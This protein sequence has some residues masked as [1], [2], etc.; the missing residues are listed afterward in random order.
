VWIQPLFL[1]LQLMAVSVT[2]ATVIGV[3]GAWAASSLEVSG[4]WG[5]LI[6]RCFLASLVVAIA[7]PMVLHA[8][9][10]EATAGKFGWM[11]MTQT[12]A[13][14][15]GTG[16]YGFFGGLFAC[17]WVHGLVGA[18]LVA[19]ATWYGVR[20][21]PSALIQQSRLEMGPIEAWWRVRL[22]LA[23]PWLLASLLAT[24]ALAATEM[25]V[26]DLYGYRTLADEFYLFY[27]ADPSIVSVLMTCFLP[28]A[29]TGVALTWLLVTRHKL[30]TTQRDP[31]RAQ[32]D[33]D[34][35]SRKWELLLMVVAT[36]V[37]AVIV[38]VPVSGLIVKLGHEV[39]VQNDLV[40]ASWSLSACLERLIAAP[41][42]FSAEYQWT[43]II[44][45]LTGLLAVVIAWP[46][47]AIG[48]T[49]RRTE[50]CIDL[51]TIVMVA[52]PGP[53][54]GLAV[55]SIFQ[56][57]V[58][59]FR[60]LYQQTLLPTILALLV[61]AGPVAYWVLRSGYRGIETS[62]LE[63]ARLDC[64]WLRRMW[65]IDGPLLKANLAAA[66]L[67]AALMAS[68]DV[69]A[70]LPVIPPGVTTVG[71]RLFGLLHSGARYQ[72]AA[73]AIWYFGAVVAICLFWLRQGVD[74]RGK[75]M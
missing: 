31:H 37:A 60:T 26:V 16:P 69:P 11:I 38:V 57:D 75:L 71:T 22:P 65:S 58:P 73:L 8:A 34:R 42:N 62:V 70:T 43:A 49:R 72:E 44:A 51:A 40:Q 47:A 32:I 4:R 13:R 29:I 30:V 18:A 3:I 20:S 61:R 28:L 41:T 12:G 24:A 5:R 39:I 63:S 48:R 15:V 10:W 56:T 21:T 46:I 19:L 36:T 14:A 23:S 50:R 54:V 68:G 52:I 6:C 17:G 53:I 25:T 35:L 67:A 27:A 59:G 33:G 55:V 7:M 64:C 9:A 1:T 2:M 74:S 66:S 45:V